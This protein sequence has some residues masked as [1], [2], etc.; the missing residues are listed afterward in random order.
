M[1]ASLVFFAVE[2]KF[3]KKFKPV[4][5]L[6]LLIINIITHAA[7]SGI[8]IGGFIPDLSLTEHQAMLELMKEELE[9]FNEETG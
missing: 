1:V 6:S 8:G 3:V 7:A 5:K 4:M 9:G 2:Q